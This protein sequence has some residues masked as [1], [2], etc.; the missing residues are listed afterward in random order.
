MEEVVAYDATEDLKKSWWLLFVLGIASVIIGGLLIFWPGRTLTV[1]ATIIGLFMIL[2]GVIRFFVAVFDSGSD[3]RWLMAIAGIVG[4][5]LGVII[6]KNPETTIKVVVLITG[7]FWLISG[8][9]DFFRGVGNKNLPDRGLRIGFGALTALF[10]IVVLVW[11]SMTVTVFAVLV[12]IYIVFFGVLE[13]FASFQL[14]N[15]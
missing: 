2:S 9:I 15:A 6:M 4:V 14:K 11:P 12:G 3:E 13:I 7:I 8:M 1:V 10:G 5:V